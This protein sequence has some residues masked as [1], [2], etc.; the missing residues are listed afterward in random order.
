MRVNFGEFPIPLDDYPTLPEGTSVI[1]P[2]EWALGKRLFAAIDVSHG[3]V[4]AAHNDVTRDGILGYFSFVSPDN[5]PDSRVPDAEI[6]TDAFV[7]ALGLI[8]RLGPPE[9]TDIWLGGAADHNDFLRDLDDITDRD[10]R[11][12]YAS[13][14]QAM[15]ELAIPE[16]HLSRMWNGEQ[17]SM[18]VQLNNPAG[19]LLIE[20]R[21]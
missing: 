10:R 5:V 20:H 21:R 18:S 1:S 12:A 9:G 6:H 13:V 19:I 16:S 8:R 4:L 7:E 11:Y 3:I 15:A 14:Q 17:G 2:G